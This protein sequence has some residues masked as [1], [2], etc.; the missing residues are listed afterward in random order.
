MFFKSMI[1]ISVV[2]VLTTGLIY[3][4]TLPA[5]VNPSVEKVK[6]EIEAPLK[7]SAKIPNISPAASTDDAQVKKLIATTSKA[8][9][10]RLTEMADKDVEFELPRSNEEKTVRPK[11]TGWTDLTKT[12]KPTNVTS[13]LQTAKT[14]SGVAVSEPF[15]KRK[16]LGQQLNEEI[17]IAEKLETPEL[18]D[19]AFLGLIDKAVR[20][21]AFNRG[22]NMAEYLSTPERRDAGRLRVMS[23]LISG[24]QVLRGY[25]VYSKLELDATKERLEQEMIATAT[26]IHGELIK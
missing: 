1:A 13:A 17:L 4:G 15:V 8:P 9:P 24:G 23:G 19:E 22:L 3:F 16:S 21:E 5:D 12:T 6:I 20:G 18:Q 26:D 7:T 10:E 11:N 14:S 2:M 25:G